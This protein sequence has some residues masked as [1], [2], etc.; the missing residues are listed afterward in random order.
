MPINTNHISSMLPYQGTSKVLVQD[1]DTD[2]I[3]KG[4]V[5]KHYKHYS[6]YDKISELFWAGTPERTAANIF[7]YLK[8]NVIYE[9]EPAEDQTVKSPGAITKDMFGDC[10]HYASFANGV[11]CSLSRKGYP[12][13]DVRF[14]YS[15]YDYMNPKDLHHVF[16]VLVDDGKEYWIDPVL[17]NFNNR[18]QYVVSKDK[19]LIMPLHEISGV[20]YMGAPKWWENIKK[21]AQNTYNKVTNAAQTNVTNATKAVTKG[22]ENTVKKVAPAVMKI[23]LSTARNSFLLLLK[24]NAFNMA[25]RLYDFIH[26]SKENEGELKNKWQ[27]MGGNF[28][29]LKNNIN[30]GMKGYLARNKT[31]AAAYNK[32]KGFMNGV[33]IPDMNTAQY[34]LVYCRQFPY[35][36]PGMTDGKGI[37]NSLGIE[38]ASAAALMT[39]AAA[40][41]AA[42]SSILQKAKWSDQDKKNAENTA[43]NGAVSVAN[44]AANNTTW[45]TGTVTLPDGSSQPMLE[46][47]VQTQADG[48]KVVSVSDTGSLQDQT[49]GGSITETLSQAVDSI[50]T[51]VIEYKT[52]IAIGV[53]S[54]LLYKSGIFQ[55]SGKPKSRK[56]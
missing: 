8:N 3:M 29:S 56:K 23:T 2:D 47:T 6:D 1:H 27:S 54:I 7:K 16:S 14:R 11:L 19:S 32:Q 24:M 17:P 33:T 5:Y 28:D 12:I 45:G 51:F 49:G 25:H 13:K 31:S 38:P 43:Q 15:G 52:P 35:N 41:I 37:K 42:L 22:A 20:D 36:M 34:Y 53:T 30:E 48:T 39:A 9:I 46:A 4:L 26:S 21:G 18:K 44:D 40:V 10:K 50:K 55:S